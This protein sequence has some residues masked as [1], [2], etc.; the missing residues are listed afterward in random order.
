MRWFWCCVT[1]CFLYLPSWGQFIRE[2]PPELEQLEF[3]IGEWIAEG[4]ITIAGKT[5]KHTS[6]H[7]LAWAVEKRWIEEHMQAVFPN[8]NPM[9]GRRWLTYS[10]DRQRFQSF[11]IDIQ[12][13]E[14]V[15]VTGQL[16]GPRRLE[17][18]GTLEWKGEIHYFKTVFQGRDANTVDV[19]YYHGMAADALKPNSKKTWRRK[20]G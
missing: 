12:T 1:L 13:D 2:V 11:W 6:H 20:T 14:P 15:N 19:T 16:T 9:N 8:G 4:E 5:S 10:K 18:S 17:L 3:L 7:Q